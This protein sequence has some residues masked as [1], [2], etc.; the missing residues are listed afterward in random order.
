MIEIARRYQEGP[1][2]RKDIARSQGISSAYLENIFM[3][4]KSRNL[5]RTVR[6][7][8]G[9]FTLQNPPSSITMFQIVSALEGPIVP[10]ECVDTYVACKQSSACAARWL[11]KKL[12]NAQISVLRKTTLQTLVDLA[13]SEKQIDYSI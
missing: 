8:N 1:V 12:Y 7:A 11:W 10:V 2:K 13:D 3:A 9:G 4:L 5:I 6:G